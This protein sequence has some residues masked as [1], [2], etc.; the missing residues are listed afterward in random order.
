MSTA[1][2]IES[3][4]DW[5]L[6]MSTMQYLG[7]TMAETHSFNCALILTT[8]HPPA[9]T[10]TGSGAQI[11]PRSRENLQQRRQ[12]RIR[13]G[14]GIGEVDHAISWRDY[15]RNMIIQL[16]FDIDN[17]SPPGADSNWKWGTDTA[18]FS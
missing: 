13:V 2:K 8:F 12:N 7:A 9:S 10:V 15:G 11:L 18:H 6:V 17:I 5:V 1:T 16:R 14:L 4:L 3:K